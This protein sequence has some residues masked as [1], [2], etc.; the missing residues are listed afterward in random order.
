[1]STT[2]RQVSVFVSYA[3]ADLDLVAR[4]VAHLGPLRDDLELIDLFWDQDLCGGDPW[5]AVIERRLDQ[6]ELVILCVSPSFV[7]SP[8]CRAE[9]ERALARLAAGETV[10]VVPVAV[11]AVYRD[12]T[13]LR[14]F[15]WLPRG[16]VAIG[17]QMHPDPQLAEVAREIR[18]LAATLVPQPAAPS[19][20][21]GGG[22]E[23][24]W[25]QPRAVR[26]ATRSR[27]LRSLEA[28]LASS[29]LAFGALAY[30]YRTLDAAS[31][32][33]RSPVVNLQLV[34]LLTTRGATPVV[35]VADPA[36]PTLLIIH[37]FDD[38]AYDDYAA[39]IREAQGQV[40]WQS[41]GLLRTNDGFTV[42]LPERS[43]PEGLYGIRI[44]GLKEGRPTQLGSFRFELRRSN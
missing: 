11:H 42:G 8:H 24:R 3:T 18:R 4:L 43:L 22:S 25:H 7:T 26:Q 10:R 37:A 6:A 31:S 9:M 12:A 38:G 27:Y 29:L 16:H 14:D 28:L 2:A 35:P 32:Q 13:P 15:N 41:V 21:E 5:R 44:F 30:H 36:R 20:A 34:D 19:H 23:Q 40:R 39:V 1:V 33:A 17:D